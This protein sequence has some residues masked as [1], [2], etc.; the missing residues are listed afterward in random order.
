MKSSKIQ[1]DIIKEPCLTLCKYVSMP[2][3]CPNALI[4]KNMFMN[5]IGPHKG[6]RKGSVDR[7]T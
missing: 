4:I 7:R 6:K 3:T 5:K 2:L 1:S